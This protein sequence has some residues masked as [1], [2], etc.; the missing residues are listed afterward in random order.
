MNKKLISLAVASAL[1]LAVASAL[2]LGRESQGRH[3]ERR[4][5]VKPAARSAADDFNALKAQLAALQDRLAADRSRSSRPRPLEVADCHSKAAH[6]ARSPGCNHRTAGRDRPHHR[7]RSRRHRRQRRRMGGPLPVEG[8][9]ALPQRERSTS[10]TFT[11]TERNRDRIRAAF[12]LLREGERYGARRDAGDDDGR[13][14]SPVPPTRRWA[15]PIRARRW[16][17]TPPT[18]NGQPNAHVES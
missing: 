5:A 17:S 14:R 1:T 6:E 15:T 11:R 9:P 12:R 16:T 8:R 18:P 13:Q 2:T 4:R 3:G 10:S 7:Q